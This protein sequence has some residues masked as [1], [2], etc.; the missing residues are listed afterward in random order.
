MLTNGNILVSVTVVGQTSGTLVISGCDSRRTDGWD[1]SQQFLRRSKDRQLGLDTNIF[2]GGQ[3][4][5]AWDSSLLGIESNSFR[6]G[7]RT[8]A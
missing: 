4:T 2:I 3:R 8:D 6:I 1:V 5:D 7:R